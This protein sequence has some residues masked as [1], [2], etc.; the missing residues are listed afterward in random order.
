M[1]CLHSLR[2]RLPSYTCQHVS[3][4]VGCSLPPLD[5]VILTAT[6][7]T[8]L[9]H[10]FHRRSPFAIQTHRQFRTSCVWSCTSC[11]RE[12]RCGRYFESLLPKYTP[13]LRHYQNTPQSASHPF[14]FLRPVSGSHQLDH[15][16]RYSDCFESRSCLRCPKFCRRAFEL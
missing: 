5:C 13:Q 3:A 2:T 12:V 8:G 4:T 6:Y 1:N 15:L 7:A 11:W 14:N 9:C 10:Y 16:L